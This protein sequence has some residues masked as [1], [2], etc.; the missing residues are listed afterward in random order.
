MCMM[1]NLKAN[2]VTMWG[3]EE[4]FKEGKRRADKNDG[5]HMQNRD[6]FLEKEGK[7]NQL[8]DGWRLRKAEENEYK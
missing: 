1:W 4:I 6:V 2:H 7:R 8:K 5:L 3:K